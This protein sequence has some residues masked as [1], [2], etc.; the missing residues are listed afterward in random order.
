MDYN[1]PD[2]N[3]WPTKLVIRIGKKLRSNKQFTQETIASNN[4]LAV[5]RRKKRAAE[6]ARKN[7]WE[8][9]PSDATANSGSNDVNE[10]GER[11]YSLFSEASTLVER[12][13]HTDMLHRLAHHDSFDSLVDRTREDD[14]LKYVKAG[15]GIEALRLVSLKHEQFIE[16]LP[17]DVWRRISSFLN[18]TD[19]ARLALSSKTLQSKLGLDPL[20]ALDLPENR[21]YKIS[22]LHSMDRHHPRHLLCF[23][24]GQ[25]H[26]RLQPGKEALKVDYISNPVFN[27]FKVKT[28]VLPRMRL[29]HAREL[30]YSFVQLATRTGHSRAHGIAHESMD[31][32]WKHSESGWSHRS[33]YMIHDNRLLMRVVSQRH[34]PPARVMTETT[35]RHLLYDRQEFTPYFSVCA[36]W[37]DGDLMKIAKCAL[38]H[39]PSPPESYLSQLKK[40]PTVSRR[41]VHPCFIVRGCDWCRPARRCPECPTEYL[42]EIQ[43]VEDSSDPIQPFKHD[44]VITRWSD[45]GDGS[46]PYTSPEW[47]AVNGISV[48]V[49]EG[50][51]AFESFAQIGRRAV[52]G[53]F[54]SRISGSI[55]GQ[56]MVSLN[57]SN[58][59]MGEEGHGWY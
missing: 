4:V 54:E 32:R 51:Q 21:H 46:S 17:E 2:L 38:S 7:K 16:S 40:A 37:K 52:S 50:G 5:E 47:A 18:P 26:L 43:M 39:V 33:R 45:L 53:I 42:V 22:F 30:P 19:A 35:E 23:P 6:Y 13:D 25:Y 27:C 14:D 44:L 28:T 12:P 55:P 34:V 11:E 57:P 48:P 9:H 36:H 24:C 1:A 20:K 58:K 41:L 59:K 31:R 29:T 15:E 49:E 3:A 56:R 8:R 10:L